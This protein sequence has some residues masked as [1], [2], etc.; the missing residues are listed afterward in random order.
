MLLGLTLLAC[1]GDLP[2]DDRVLPELTTPA[3][4]EVALACDVG[5]SKWRLDATATSWTGGGHLYWTVDGEYVE[6]H[7]VRSISAAGDGSSDTLLL[8]LSVA[9]DWR[10]VSSGSSTAFTCG[11]DPAW[12][13]V[14]YDTE[15]AVADCR[16]EGDEALWADQ[17][18]VPACP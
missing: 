11:Q 17:P 13:L 15:E 10:E 4:D 18:D 8:E 9:A 7:Y 3:L 6:K 2:P 1:G 16:A 5:E 12:R 14:I